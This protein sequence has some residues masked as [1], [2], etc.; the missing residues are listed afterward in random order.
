MSLRP[1]WRLQEHLKEPS[2]ILSEMANFRLYCPI[3]VRPND[4][5]KIGHINNVAYFRYLEAARLFYWSIV[6]GSRRRIH[7]D[8]ILAHAEL[9]YRQQANQDHPLRVGIRTTRL[10]ISSFDFNYEV[11]QDDTDLLL[12]KGRSTQVMFDYSANR[13]VAL[14]ESVRKAIIDLE[15][16]EN[17]K[18]GSRD[19]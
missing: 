8:L 13:S 5:D 6:F 16:L 1:L 9:D 11:L 17:L 10:G 19:E 12:G 7:N 2:G 14:P 15:G 18:C 3:V 4:I